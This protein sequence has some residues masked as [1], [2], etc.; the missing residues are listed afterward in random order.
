MN[1]TLLM[2]NQDASES[3]DDSFLCS[4]SNNEENKVSG[5]ASI[6]SNLA[7]FKGETKRDGEDFSRE[8]EATQIDR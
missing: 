4:D 2:S 3:Q 8:Q 5:S 1:Q 6:T 7:H